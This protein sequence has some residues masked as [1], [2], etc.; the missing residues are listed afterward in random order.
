ME[1]GNLVQR[2]RDGALGIILS[3]HGTEAEILFG[4]GVRE[5]EESAGLTVVSFKP[6]AGIPATFIEMVEAYLTT[7][8]FG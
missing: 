3:I 2:K 4:D 5:I 6:G 8:G 1:K 7:R